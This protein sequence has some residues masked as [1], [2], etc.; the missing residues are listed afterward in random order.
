MIRVLLVDDDMVARAHSAFVERTP[1]FCVVGVAR[2]GAGALAAGRELQPDPVLVELRRRLAEL[3][4]GPAT[5]AERSEVDSLF[6]PGLRRQAAAPLPDGLSSE[7]LALVQRVL[8]EAG[9]EG[10]SASVCAERAGLSRL[11]ARRSLGQVSRSGTAEVSARYGGT[12][13]PERR[14]SA[15]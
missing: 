13:R 10:I 2:D 11:S 6:A 14:F 5:G 1:G 8:C 12:G 15:P 7:T 9:A 3:P 4:C